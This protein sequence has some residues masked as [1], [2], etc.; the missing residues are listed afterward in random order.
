MPQELRRRGRPTAGALPCACS[1][2][3]PAVRLG[4]HDDPQEVHP[5]LVSPEH[6]EL[7]LRVKAMQ[8]QG[9]SLDAIRLALAGDESVDVAAPATPLVHRSRWTRVEL[10][11]GVE[12]QLSSG[13]RMPA[14]RRLRELIEKLTQA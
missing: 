8:E 1:G 9:I 10:M 5:P 13:R 4:R 11:P 6:L 12:L 14:P 7:L 3:G 2:L